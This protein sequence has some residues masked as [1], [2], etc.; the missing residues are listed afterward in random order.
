[1][2][3]DREA[4]L[5]QNDPYVNVGGIVA[6]LSA[7]TKVAYVTIPVMLGFFTWLTYFSFEIAFR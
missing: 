7:H 6:P 2:E 5:M 4:S 3:A 1:V